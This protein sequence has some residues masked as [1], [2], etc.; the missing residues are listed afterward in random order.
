MGDSGLPFCFLAL[1]VVFSSDGGFSPPNPS[2]FSGIRLFILIYQKIAVLC[3]TCFWTI[4]GKRKKERLIA[5]YLPLLYIYDICWV[6][7]NRGTR[8]QLPTFVEAP[9]KTLSAL[10]FFFD[11]LA[12]CDW[13]KWDLISKCAL[14]IVI[15]QNAT[16]IIINNS[17]TAFSHYHSFFFSLNALNVCFI[18]VHNLNRL[19]FL[20]FTKELLFYMVRL[21]N[22]FNMKSHIVSHE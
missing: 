3:W 4:S 21:Y 1:L 8:H 20:F 15:C 2:V 14:W 6:R 9:S 5:N 16:N 10:F 13:E 12:I 22:G 7:Y 17:K 18:I 11:R 19:D